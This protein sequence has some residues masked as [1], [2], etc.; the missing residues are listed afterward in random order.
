TLVEALDRNG[1]SAQAMVLLDTGR[2]ELPPV[3]AMRRA[4]LM[5]D[6]GDLPGAVKLAETV[7]A[8]SDARSLL[9]RLADITRRSNDPKATGRAYE[10]LEA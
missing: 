3:L 4:E 8:N 6:A 1:Q 10:R 2:T 9:V 5:A 7:A